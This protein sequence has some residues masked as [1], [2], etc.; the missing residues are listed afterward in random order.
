[1]EVSHIPQGTSRPES[2]E[3][4]GP[5]GTAS[6]SLTRSGSATPDLFALLLAQMQ[7][8]LT[9]QPESEA[10]SGA[11]EESSGDSPEESAP[12]AASDVDVAEATGAEQ[13]EA[14]APMVALA[15]TAVQANAET[16]GDAVVFLSAT[17]EAAQSAEVQPARVTKPASYGG[18]RASCFGRVSRRAG[19]KPG[20]RQHHRAGGSAD[21]AVRRSLSQGPGQ[22]RGADPSPDLH[23]SPGEGPG[24]TSR[25]GCGPGRLPRHQHR[26]KRKPRHGRTR[27]PFRNRRKTTA[28]DRCWLPMPRWSKKP[29]RRFAR[30]RP[31]SGLNRCPE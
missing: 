19:A 17:E 30:M 16:A 15:S 14:T 10:V 18:S 31:W 11:T 22:S 20:S 29:P 3:A 5:P 9:G 6:K 4:S 27:Q 21:R 13:P 1:M 24:G 8:M 2:T 7:A 25:A 12:E 28:R 26:I 23:R